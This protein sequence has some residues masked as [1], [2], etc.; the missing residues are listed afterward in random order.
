MLLWHMVYCAT[1]ALSVAGTVTNADVKTMLFYTCNACAS[2]SRREYASILGA[3]NESL[4]AVMLHAQGH[5]NDGA[6]TSV[7]EVNLTF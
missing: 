7:Q 3:Q 4:H 2:Q 5:P 1:L 6:W